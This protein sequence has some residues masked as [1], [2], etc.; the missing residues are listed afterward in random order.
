MMRGVLVSFGVVALVAAVVGVNLS[1]EPGRIDL[2]WRLIQ[3]PARKI[4]AEPLS[5]GAIV[6]T[7]TAPGKIESVEEA[8]IA[9]Q[10]IGRVTAVGFKEGD[11]VK[12]GDVLVQIDPTDAQ[13]RLD[14]TR[15]R[16]SRLKSAIDQADSDLKKARRDA[17]LSTKLADRGFSTPTE[18]A[19]SYTSLAKAE[20]A[21]EM[22]RNELNES[23]AMRRSSEEDVKRTTIRAPI[24]GVVSGLN[25]DVGEIVIAGTTNL[26]GSVLMKVC[27]MNRMR[28]RADIDETDVLLVRSSQ[29]ARIFPQADQLH[30][31]A[32]RIDRVAPQ[33]KIKKDDVVSFETLVDLTPTSNGDGQPPVSTL[34]PGMS[35]TV[36]VEVRRA[37]EALSAPAQ[38]VVHRRRK[39]LP[40][41]PLIREWAE[42][43]VRAP[44]EKA[45]DSEVRYLK[46]MFV[47]DG[48]VA[49]AR[50]IDVG[51]SDERRVEVRSG[52]EA[53][54][55]VIV[56]PFHALDEL[57][58]GDPVVPV[59]TAA[60]LDQPK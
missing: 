11:A 37:D 57:K 19:D 27:D 54:E 36:E 47:V 9:S 22:C 40:D 56:G 14:S 28:V 35:V 42:R 13:A 44:G 32:G 20:A 58:D 16:I 17:G 26:P 21:L 10:I 29:P 38:A 39:D 5:H 46:V 55:R 33:G 49:R 24:D 60:E 48:E 23:E 4:L 18:L 34:R 43:A 25:V 12:K 41:T 53:D 51:L 15:A 2:D 3:E 6:Q 7:I 52:V 45:R 1:R 8:E 50:P 31:V 59:A 30:P